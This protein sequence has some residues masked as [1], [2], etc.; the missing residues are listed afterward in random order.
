MFNPTSKTRPIKPVKA[1]ALCH[2]SNETNHCC[3]GYLGGYTTFC[4]R[5]HY[6]IPCKESLLNSQDFMDFVRTVWIFFP[7]QKP[8]GDLGPRFR[9]VSW[10]KFP[11]SWRA[12][13]VGATYDVRCIPIHGPRNAHVCYEQTGGGYS[14]NRAGC[15]IGGSKV[16]LWKNWSCAMGVEVFL[17]TKHFSKSKPQI[18]HVFGMSDWKAIWVLNFCCEVGF[19][20]ECVVVFFFLNQPIESCWLF[21][22]NWM[23]MKQISTKNPDPW[24]NRFLWRTLGTTCLLSAVCFHSQRTFAAGRGS[25]VRLLWHMVLCPSCWPYSMPKGRLEMGPWRRSAQGGLFFCL[26]LSCA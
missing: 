7:L 13:M 8:M 17:G 15:W 26:E 4:Y 14:Y 12:A 22:K 5:V 3:L 1:S 10:I 25:I 11:S 24:T 9:K 23:M 19:G 18:Q 16:E 21:Q 2:L 6:T 20:F